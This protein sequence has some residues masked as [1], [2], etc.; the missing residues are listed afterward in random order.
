MELDK[1]KIAR[2]KKQKIAYEKRTRIANILTK[3]RTIV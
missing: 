2:F 1:R 3:S